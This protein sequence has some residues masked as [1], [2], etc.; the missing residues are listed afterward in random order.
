VPA[1]PRGSG[2]GFTLIELL[3]VI[4]II[5]ILAGLLLPALSAAKQ[6]GMT[7]RCQSNVRQLGLGLSMY[8][9]DFA[10]YPVY[11]YESETLEEN[12]FWHLR[13]EPYTRSAWTNDLFRCPAY[14]GVTVNGSDVAVPLGSYGY[15]AHGTAY[16]FSEL[17][18][19]GRFSKPPPGVDVP[20]GDETISA[21]PESAVRAPSDMIAL[22]DAHLIVVSPII[23]RALYGLQGPVNYSGMALLDINSR[24]HVQAPSWPG[25][26][27]AIKATQARHRGRHNVLFCDGHIEG[28]LESKL[29][30][31]TDD[32]LRRWN[33]DNEPHADRLV[34]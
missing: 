27:G 11:N 2:G 19:G 13:L 17:G 31:R 7:A 15:N 29:F 6:A 12:Q 4:A 25:S 28:S 1:V 5:A 14:K 34:K 10:R 3:V 20:Q 23:L 26:S 21:I 8:L 30:A 18:L 16:P 22:G 9:Q 32:A 24:N 33:S